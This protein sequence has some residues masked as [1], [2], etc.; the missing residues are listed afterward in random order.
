LFV[1]TAR[2]RLSG[3]AL[4]SN[5]QL[6]L[7]KFWLTYEG[8]LHAAG[9]AERKQAIRRQFRPQLAQLY[10][11][12]PVLQVWVRQHEAG[13]LSP[14]ADFAVK[15]RPFQFRPLVRIR[16]NMTATLK[17][18]LLEHEYRPLIRARKGDLDNRVKTLVDALRMPDLPQEISA[19]D[20]PRQSETPFHCLLETDALVRGICVE[21]G[22]LLTPCTQGEGR[23]YVRA[24]IE[25]TV[26]AQADS[27]AVAINH[28]G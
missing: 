7:M 23:K 12:D 3:N 27:I 13:M 28:N 19:T 6:E 25:V 9:N 26:N 21:T 1:A 8:D 14:I 2:G 20:K 5:D 17:I 4:G 18:L 11:V 22:K 24:T 16:E 10:E 15:D